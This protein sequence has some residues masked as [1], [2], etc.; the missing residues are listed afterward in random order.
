V[1]VAIVLPYVLAGVTAYYKSQQFGTVD[2][3][4]PR[5]QAAA[6]TG[7]GA[8]ADAAQKNAWEALTVFIPAVVVAH[9]AGAA[10]VTAALASVIFIV[11]R[12]LHPVFYI[13]NLAPLRTLS[14][15]VGTGC[16]L[17]LFWLAATA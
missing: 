6:L 3:H 10:P 12:I 16:C 7:A 9:L 14:F 17:W 2:A 4:H 15:T 5:T 1:L 13:A 11:A 8:R